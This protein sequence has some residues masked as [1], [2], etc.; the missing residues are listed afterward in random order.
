MGGEKDTISTHIYRGGLCKSAP[1]SAHALTSALPPINTSRH[2]LR[3]CLR[4]NQFFGILSITK[5]ERSP[6]NLC[7]TQIL[8][9]G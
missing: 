4:G 8:F 6:P 9:F 3:T 5:G 2:F 1:G 7:S